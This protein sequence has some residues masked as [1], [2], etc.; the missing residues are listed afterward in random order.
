MKTLYNYWEYTVVTTPP[1]NKTLTHITLNP[2]RT[3]V[4]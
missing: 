2:T 4:A 1:P 3:Q